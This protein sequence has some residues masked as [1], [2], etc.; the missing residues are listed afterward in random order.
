MERIKR[1]ELYIEQSLKCLRNS[2]EEI[3]KGEYE[4]AGELLWG[5]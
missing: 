3:K 4:K 2:L 5:A 1:A